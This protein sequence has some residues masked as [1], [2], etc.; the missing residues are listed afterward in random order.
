MKAGKILEQAS[1]LS[2]NDIT[3]STITEVN[4]KEN[5]EIILI[6]NSDQYY[7]FVEGLGVFDGKLIKVKMEK[8]L[9]MFSDTILLNDY[10]NHLYDLR[11]YQNHQVIEFYNIDFNTK[12]LYIK[13]FGIKPLKVL[14]NYDY[15]D[16][17][18]SICETNKVVEITFNQ[19]YSSVEEYK[20]IWK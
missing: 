20:N 9:G 3:I 5:N 15:T 14:F 16:T 4:L 19:N 7:K 18:E 6:F 1:C 17:R 12:K 8:H 10:S 11:Y 2:V 13:N